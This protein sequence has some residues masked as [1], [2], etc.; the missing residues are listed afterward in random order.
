MN[1]MLKVILPVM[2][3]S[4]LL[5]SGCSGDSEA[6]NGDSEAPNNEEIQAPDFQLESLEG[7]TV[8]L[9][10]LRGNVV[11]L[12][13]WTT[14]CGYCIVEMP[15]LEQVYAEW[16]EAGLVL[17]TI[18]MGESADKVTTFLQDNGFSLPVLLDIDLT[19][20]TQ[21]GVASIPR[22]FLIDQDGLVQAVKI[23]A[24]QSVAEIEA[25]LTMFVPE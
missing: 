12:N 8:R 17:L 13:F 5:I 18:N 20:A 6:P 24:F 7:Q 25:G 9:S 16:Q 14:T 2:L 19:V 23:G 1:K 3:I 4:V 21:Y 11:L 10:D 22:T 15:F